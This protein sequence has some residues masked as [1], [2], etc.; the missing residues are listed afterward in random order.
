MVNLSFNVVI[1]KDRIERMETLDQIANV[2]LISIGIISL[3]LNMYLI[4]RRDM[5]IDSLL[6]EIEDKLDDKLDKL[7]DHVKS[8]EILDHVKEIKTKLKE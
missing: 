8:Q 2:I 6:N 3:L 4:K 5:P 1:R 7:K